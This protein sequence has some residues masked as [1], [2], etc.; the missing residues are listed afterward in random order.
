[1]SL[2]WDNVKEKCIF[3]K[4]SKPH[5]V[6]WVTLNMIVVK[7]KETFPYMDYW[8]LGSKLCVHTEENGRVIMRFLHV[9]VHC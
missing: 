3:V 4:S 1:M 2:I 5:L 7:V 6:L 8:F 9:N